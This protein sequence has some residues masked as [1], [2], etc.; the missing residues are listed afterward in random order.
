MSEEMKTLVE[1][2]NKGFEEFK[3]ANDERLAQIESKSANAD[4]V[5]VDK[6]A[7][8][9]A[10]LA[11]LDEKNDKIVLAQKRRDRAEEMGDDFEA[12]AAQFADEVKLSTGRAMAD[13]AAQFLP[14]YKAAF[15]SM[16]RA[17]F[18]PDVLTPDERKSLSVGVDSAGGYL[19]EPDMSGR[20]VQKVFETSAVRAF[21]SV[22]SISS[23]A[24]EGIY[25]NDE[26]GF[27]WVG[28]TAARASTST[29][30][31]GKWS[32]PVH[33]VFAFPDATQKLLDDAMVNVEA[34]LNDKI[35]DKFAR[36]ENAAFV[37]GSGV[38][39]PRGFMTYADGTD[40]TNSVQRTKTGVNGDFAAAPAGGD[41][42]I[43]MI[44][45]LKA[46]YSGN[47]YWYM[48]RASVGKARKLKDSDGA[49][50][51]AQSLAAGT[52][53]TLLGYPVAPA[54]EDMDDFATGALPIAFGDL[55]AAYQIVDRIGIRMLR[56]PYTNK[57][58]VGFY[59][60]K[61]TGG[62]LI[63]GEAIKIL[64]ASS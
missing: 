48:N 4:P 56:D 47:A 57:P 12:K 29:P 46:A 54:F 53:S 33:E 21:A 17:N 49:Y 39:K 60:T 8:I 58:R 23:D 22:Q 64:E 28:E 5:T 63:N 26:V 52:P 27:G 45:D 59:A 16:V 50:I 19:V 55:R 2:L 20:I 24:L 40:L 44:S 61:R 51:W 11:K 18:N 7:K 15:N 36:A 32:V 42:L 10:D 38:D 6:L 3:S 41:V 14:E 43:N 37:G 62:D 31:L 34:L 9:E 35:A 1:G 25:D 13:D 30:A